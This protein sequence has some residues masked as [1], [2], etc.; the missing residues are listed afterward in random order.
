[1]NGKNKNTSPQ[2]KED[3]YTQT[4][5]DKG[6]QKS[7]SQTSFK[8]SQLVNYTDFNFSNIVWAPIEHSFLAIHMYLDP[9]TNINILLWLLFFS[10]SAYLY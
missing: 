2:K 7:Y 1:M 9:C 10:N 5:V 8:C 4:N 6:D 3:F